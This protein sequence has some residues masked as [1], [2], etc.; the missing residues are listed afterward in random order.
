MGA[1]VNISA[2]IVGL[3]AFAGWTFLRFGVSQHRRWVTLLGGVGILA[4]SFSVV[5]PDDDD[6]QQEWIRP[7]TPSVRVTAHC[8]VAPRRSPAG[9]TIK[10]FVEAGDPTRVTGAGRSFA[11][12]QPL[13]LDTHFHALIS[14]HSP[15][16][17]S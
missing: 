10:A 17:A 3:T 7:A 5:C 15:P 14:I 13:E 12:D 2:L 9:L 4:L 1:G 8:R 11:K 6:F 16:S